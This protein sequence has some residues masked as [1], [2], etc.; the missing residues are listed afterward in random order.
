[1][2]RRS[3][4]VQ[5]SGKSPYSKYGKVPYKYNFPTGA[6]YTDAKLRGHT[7]AIR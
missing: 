6:A 5:K 3:F 4:K 1:M 7:N 2:K